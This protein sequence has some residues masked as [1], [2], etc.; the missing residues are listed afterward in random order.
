VHLVA[1]RVV[2]AVGASASVVLARAIV[3]DLYDRDEAARVLSR[4]MTIMAVAP[5]LGPSVGSLVF[6]LGSD[7]DR[8]S[9]FRR[10]L[11][12]SGNI[13]DAPPGHA[14]GIGCIQGLW[15]RFEIPPCHRLHRRCGTLLQRGLR[16]YLRLIVCLHRIPRANASALRHRFRGRRGRADDDKPTEREIGTASWCRPHVA[17]RRLRIGG[18]RRRLGNCDSHGLRRRRGHGN[19]P[20]V[21]HRDERLHHGKSHFRGGSWVREERGSGIGCSRHGPVGKW[22]PSRRKPARRIA[23][24]AETVDRNCFRSGSSAAARPSLEP[25]RFE[26]GGMHGTLSTLT[27]LVATLRFGIK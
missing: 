18:G 11:P 7:G 9:G 5:L 23:G 25:R 19:M 1:W 26:W 6:L 4:L 12:A 3:R 22:V 13:A 16:Q 15:Q 14:T 20:L 24:P 2:Q 8:N 17:H 10:S 21:L 27:P